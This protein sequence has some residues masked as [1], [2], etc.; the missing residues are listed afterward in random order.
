MSR[1]ERREQ[2]ISVARQLFG[3]GGYD[4]VSIEEIAAAAEVSKPVVYE[5]FG[6]KE[7][8]YQVIVDREVTALSEIFS[9]RMR[10]E[11]AP[12]EVLEGIVLS[13]LD[14]IEDNPDGF[15]L[16]AH[17][18]PTA[19][20]S[21]TFATVIA[22]VADQVVDRL[23]P[24]MDQRGLDPATAPVYGQLLAGGV[25]QIGQW[26]SEHRTLPKESVAAHVTNLLWFGLRNMEREPHLITRPS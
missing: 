2:L 14:Y 5:H 24:L 13:L 19:V 6:G 15:H 1:S 18:S 22:D 21:E 16:L 20:R 11:L 3:T 4:A 23:A 10:P 25:G 9:A 17:Q 26:W 12:R 8:L 7:G